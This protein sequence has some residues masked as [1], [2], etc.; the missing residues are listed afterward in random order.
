[1]LD[2]EI[3]FEVD[4]LRIVGRLYLPGQ[5]ASFPA[6]CVCHGIPHE[7]L[8]V[9]SDVRDRGYPGLAENICREGFVALIFNFRGTGDS[10]GNFDILGWTHDLRA[11]VNYL[12]SLPEVSSSSLSLLGFS[13]GAAVAV[14]VAA[15]DKRISSLVAC[16]CPAEF[17]S[18][19]PGGD[20]V[21]SLIEHFRRLGVIRDKDFPG[22]SQDWLDSFRRVSPISCVSRISPRPL[23]LV[24]GE[25][26]ETVG[27]G[28]ARRLYARAREPKQIVIIEGVRHQLRQDERAMA[29]V[30][31][32]LKSQAR[33]D[34]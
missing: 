12:R 21:P 31:R 26:D 25:Q 9:D 2:R 4:G 18:L 1:V 24:H 5:W 34:A 11:A 8:A 19:I 20:G 23:L 32:W 10:G 13:G 22:S 30:T 28:H 15:R 17:D 14:Y 16:A 6:V 3:A 7:R 27:V 33:T 29:T